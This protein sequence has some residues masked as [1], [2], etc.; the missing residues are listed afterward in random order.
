MLAYKVLGKVLMPLTLEQEETAR[1]WLRKKSWVR[2]CPDCRSFRTRW[3]FGEIL[4]APELAQDGSAT[5]E[6][7]I[8]M[9]QVMCRNCGFI[10]LFSAVKMGIIS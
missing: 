7:S 10:R 2:S 5:I 3:I 8:P 9:L 1:A 4:A 6:S